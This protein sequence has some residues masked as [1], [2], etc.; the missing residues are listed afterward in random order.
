MKRAQEEEKELRRKQ[1][2]FVANIPA[3]IDVEKSVKSVKKY[4]TK[5]KKKKKKPLQGDDK[6]MTAINEQ[7][8]EHDENTYESFRPQGLQR[9]D[10]SSYRPFD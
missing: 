10:P 1:A 6:T 4:I 9:Q 2:A 3:K 5:P 8:S 7:D